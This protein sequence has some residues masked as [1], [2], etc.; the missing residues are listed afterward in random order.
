MPATVIQITDCHRFADPL[1]ELKG[2]CT[3]AE[4]GRVRA[5]LDLR[6]V[7]AA[8]PRRLV[9][10]GDLAH[11]ELP[12]TYRALRMELAGWLPR[13]RVIPGNHDRRSTLRENFADVGT[14]AGFIAADPERVV[15]VDRFPGWCLV[16]LDTQEPAELHGRLG[17]P[18]LAWLDRELTN[19][20]EYP[21]VIFLHHPP[22]SVASSWLDA[23]GLTDAAELAQ[24]VAK[25]PHVQA[26]CC[27]HVHQDYSGWLGRV[28]VYATPSTAV[29][30][31]PGTAALE[32][33]PLPPGYRVLELAEDGG[34]RTAVI[35]V[36]DAP[37]APTA[38]VAPV[39]ASP[40]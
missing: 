29:Q 7:D 19:H 17:Q 25:H 6:L 31:R 30:F 18:Q 38:P 34:L 32:I 11:D 8:P 5:D 12:E 23:I 1:A 39:L 14:E 40:E 21:T 35:R 2:I 36:G 24:V 33:D 20:R 27:G 28:P 10:T 3:R 22:I 26:I 13:L 37:D 9:I 16:G 15:F 4:L